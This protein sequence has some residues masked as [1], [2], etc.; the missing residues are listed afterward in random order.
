MESQQKSLLL[1]GGMNSKQRGKWGRLRHIDN[2]GRIR[3]S[4]ERNLATALTELK[5]IS[6]RMSF[7]EGYSQKEAGL[8]L[9]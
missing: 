2:R 5:R 9:P 4:T 7:T 6:S 3:N 1:G 8:H